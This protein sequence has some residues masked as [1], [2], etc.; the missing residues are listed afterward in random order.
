MEYTRCEVTNAI[1]REP[2]MVLVALCNMYREE[3]EKVRSA[4]AVTA[5]SK[6]NDG[7]GRYF[8]ESVLRAGVRDAP[9]RKREEK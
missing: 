4:A 3:R 8:Y 2:K 6:K 1:K 9:K 5:C 7:T